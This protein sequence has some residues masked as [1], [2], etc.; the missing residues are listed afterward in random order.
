MQ[1]TG[2]H[3]VDTEP[4]PIARIVSAGVKAVAFEDEVATAAADI[5]QF[6]ESH[7]AVRHEEVYDER[8]E[9]PFGYSHRDLGVVPGREC[10]GAQAVREHEEGKDQANGGRPAGDAGDSEAT[11]DQAVSHKPSGPA[12]KEGFVRA[13]GE[14]EEGND[15]ATGEARIREGNGFESSAELGGTNSSSTAPVPAFPVSSPTS[16]LHIGGQLLDPSHSTH[17]FKGVVF[18]IRCGSCSVDQ[19]K[20]LGRR[21]TGHKS[22]Q[23]K[24]NID[25]IARGVP[26]GSLRRGPVE[27]TTRFDT[28]GQLARR[29]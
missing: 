2:G 20:S 25:R 12:S 1:F 15:Q 9:D 29:I 18:S 11:G 3:Y 16:A 13:S 14:L 27:S 26:P 8:D 17:Y 6:D 10:D 24:L 23:G 22:Q 19:A 28:A 21:C 4:E 7:P 5:G